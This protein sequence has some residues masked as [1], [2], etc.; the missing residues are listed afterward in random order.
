MINVKVSGKM[1][2]RVDGKFTDTRVYKNIDVIP[3][4][5]LAT[6]Y[7]QFHYNCTKHQKEEAKTS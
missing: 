3:V 5:E 6:L 7:P 1:H 2:D 4:E